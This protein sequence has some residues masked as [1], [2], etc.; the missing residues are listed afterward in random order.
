MTEGL[1]TTP[2]RADWQPFVQDAI[3]RNVG[4]LPSDCAEATMR[5]LAIAGP[6]LNG[7]SFDV[8]TDFDEVDRRRAEIA[9]ERWLTMRLRPLP[10][11]S[12]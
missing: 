6:E 4:K 11:M 12:G 9:R 10:M 3:A 2:E 1:V 8:E 5:L 7:C